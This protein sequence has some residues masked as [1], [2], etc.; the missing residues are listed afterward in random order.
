MTDEEILERIEQ[1]LL[2]VCHET[3]DVHHYHG[4]WQRFHKKVPDQHPISGRYRFRFGK[5][6]RTL[7]RN[8]LVWMY[9]HRR[10]VPKGYVVDHEDGDCEND[11]PSNL[12]LMDARTSHQQGFAC[13][14][15]KALWEWNCLLDYIEF[16]G[17]SPPEDSVL[18]T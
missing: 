7:F 15:D 9:F 8:K 1:G 10:I 11:H 18:W 16:M 3:L 12:R 6:R 13:L 14:E 5:K 17:A 4:R 2:H